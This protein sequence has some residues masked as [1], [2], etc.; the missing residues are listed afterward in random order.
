VA[1]RFEKFKQVVL[2]FEGVSQIGQGF[3]D[4][5]FRVFAL[6]HPNVRLVPVNTSEAVAQMIRRVT[7]SR[8]QTS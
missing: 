4:E 5:L 1:H 7:A 2:D 3:A 8:R 6:D